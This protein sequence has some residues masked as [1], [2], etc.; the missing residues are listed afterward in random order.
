MDGTFS[1]DGHTTWYDASGTTEEGKLPIVILHGGP[2]ATHD[3]LEDLAVLSRSGRQTILYDQIGCGNSEHLPA[4]PASF[5]TTGLFKRELTGL[6]E[7]LGIDDA[8]TLLGQSWGGML[9]ME[10]AL[11]HPEG[12]KGMVVSN[13]PASIPLW[14]EEANRLR[15]GLPPE[16]QEV[17]LHHEAAGTTDDPAYEAAVTVFYERHLCRVPW[18][19]C[20]VRAFALMDEDPTVYHTMNGPS[21]FHCIGSLKDWDITDR[22][23]EID[24]PTLLISGEYDEATPRVVKAIDDRIPDSEWV[25]FE[26]ASHSTHIEEPEKYVAAVERF[27]DRIEA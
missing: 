11:D 20:M 15:K 16:V 27:L 9:A 13:S 22:L 10:H 5:W 26:G 25:L 7:H 12:L 8:Y 21:E 3:Y 23:P 4:A 24:V 14:V 17:L 2:G 19:E 18:P 6:L 1:W